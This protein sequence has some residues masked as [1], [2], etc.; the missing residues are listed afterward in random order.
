MSK[1]LSAKYYQENKERIQM[2]SSWKILK[3]SQKRKRRKGTLCL[4]TV[5]NFYRRQKE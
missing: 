1:H 5:Q 3:S 4:W 2:K